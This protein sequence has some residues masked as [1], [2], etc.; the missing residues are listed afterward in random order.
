VGGGG[1]GRGCVC[2]IRSWQL[3]CSTF[4]YGYVVQLS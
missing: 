2:A 3:E 1:G 4:M